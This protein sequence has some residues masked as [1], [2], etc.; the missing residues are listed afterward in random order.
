[1]AQGPPPRCACGVSAASTSWLPPILDDQSPPGRSAGHHLATPSPDRGA[2]SHPTGTE[3]QQIFA[4][5]DQHVLAAGF[6]LGGIK[7]IFVLIGGIIA[8]VICTLI[9]K[10]KGYSAI[11]FAVLGFFFSII[12]LIVILVI[13]RKR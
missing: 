3:R 12:T 8:A 5:P 7:G 1:M 6:I 13:P 10:S 11:L 4:S 2:G 9:A